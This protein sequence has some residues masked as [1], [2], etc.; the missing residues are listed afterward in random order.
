M[1]VTNLK[2]KKKFSEGE[3]ILLL[4]SVDLSPTEIAKILGKKS[5]T[6]ISYAF[7]P[8]KEESNKKEQPKA[9]GKNEPEQKGEK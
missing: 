3:A 7:Y 1:R 5:A 9:Q 6:D 4:K 8:K 2:K